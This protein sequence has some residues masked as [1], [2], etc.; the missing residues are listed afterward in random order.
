MTRAAEQPDRDASPEELAAIDEAIADLGAIDERKAI[1]VTL[2]LF[3]GL[4]VAETANAIDVSSATVTRD[5]RFA[6]AWLANRLRGTVSG[7]RSA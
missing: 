2:H 6:R 3:V 5:W 7:D 4:S 1:V